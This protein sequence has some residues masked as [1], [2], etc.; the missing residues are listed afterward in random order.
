[1]NMLFLVFR[2]SL[3]EDM[4][5]RFSRLNGRAFT[6]A[7]DMLGMGE[8]EAPFDSSPM[9]PSNSMILA[10]LEEDQTERVIEGLK[11]FRDQVADR[12]PT[13]QFPSVPSSCP[14]NR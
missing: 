7:P 11:V 1:M 6:E 12:N 9:R 5:E 14:A 10:A 2:H 8:T 4:L 13:R 3:E